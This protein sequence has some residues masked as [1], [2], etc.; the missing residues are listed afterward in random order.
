[1]DVDRVNP[2][3]I[4]IG[5]RSHSMQIRV[6]A[7]VECGLE[8]QCKLEGQNF[9]P[10]WWPLGRG[11]GVSFRGST[12]CTHVCTFSHVTRRNRYTYILT[13]TH[14][15]VSLQ[16][17]EVPESNPTIMVSV[18]VASGCGHFFHARCV[19]GVQ[20]QSAGYLGVKGQQIRSLL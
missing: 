17:G 14:I 10:Q 20:D 19:G 16:A 13:S 5:G 3:S 15:Q 2:D 6:N 4:R 12:N 8:P 7:W 9:I 11:S 1:M 18:G